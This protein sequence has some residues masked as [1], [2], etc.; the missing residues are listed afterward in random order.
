MKSLQSNEE[1]V[2]MFLNKKKEETEILDSSN[3][4]EGSRENFM[5]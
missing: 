1:P 3:S 4:K 2:L 5:A